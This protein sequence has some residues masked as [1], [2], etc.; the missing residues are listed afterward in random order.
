MVSSKAQL[1]AA[2]RV[3][4][5]ASSLH[6]RWSTTGKGAVHAPSDFA[7]ALAAADVPKSPQG[8]VP[9]PADVASYEKVADFLGI[10]L[11]ALGP[12]KDLLGSQGVAGRAKT[13]PASG[14]I[15]PTMEQLARYYL[16]HL[17]DRAHTRA[18]HEA[19]LRD[20]ILLQFGRFRLD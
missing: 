10:D 1:S 6:V 3:A 11:V 14:S 4:W 8:P 2:C 15:P 16:T 19:C 13:A 20:H 17:G 18:I 9:L 7:E 5:P 12:A